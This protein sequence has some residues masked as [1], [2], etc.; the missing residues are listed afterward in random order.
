MKRAFLEFSFPNAGGGMLSADYMRNYSYE[1][2]RDFANYIIRNKLDYENLEKHRKNKLIIEQL[3]VFENLLL[4]A[5]SPIKGREQGIYFIVCADMIWQVIIKLL[6]ISGC[7]DVFLSE[8]DV[9]QIYKNIKKKINNIYYFHSFIR[10][11]TEDGLK[12]YGWILN[13]EWKDEEKNMVRN[14]A[15]IIYKLVMSIRMIV[16]CDV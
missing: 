7:V 9:P 5:F 11:P 12:D 14:I 8:E 15:Q 1:E 6:G 4:E 2:I 13:R 3:G 10:H 16:S